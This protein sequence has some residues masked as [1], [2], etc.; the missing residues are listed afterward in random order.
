M[1]YDHRAGVAKL[2]GEVKTVTRSANE[3]T[4]MTSGE[5]D[6]HFA[7][8]TSDN[9]GDATSTPAGEQDNNEARDR[10]PSASSAQAQQASAS[11]EAPWVSNEKPQNAANEASSSEMIEDEASPRAAASDRDTP[12]GAA[13]APAERNATQPSGPLDTGRQLEKLVARE[14]AVFVAR[15]AAEDESGRPH[16]RLRLEGPT[17]RFSRAEERVVVPG[18][19]RLLVEDHRP[20]AKPATQPAPSPDEAE[21][22]P[23]AQ[24]ADGSEGSAAPGSSGV[25]FTGRGETL[26]TW[27]GSLTLDAARSDMLIE[28]DV[29]MIYRPLGQAPPLTLSCQRLLADL[30]DAGGLGMWLSNDAPDTELQQVQ[31]DRDV[32][33]QRSGREITAQHLKYTAGDRRVQFWSAEPPL[34]TV[35]SQDEPTALRAHRVQWDLRQNQ[36]RASGVEGGSVPAPAENR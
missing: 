24:A 11:P 14:A 10:P 31:A 12:E 6:L 18:S 27:T 33:L 16:T 3:R 2:R 28:E 15:S 30:A 22:N 32:R 8:R 35:T 19:G 26:F 20:Q 7:E 5:L 34:V 29:W 25:D 23:P 36:L 4:R 13:T 21:A 17:I 1:Q 9:S